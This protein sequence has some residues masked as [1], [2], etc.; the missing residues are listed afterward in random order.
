MF[1]FFLPENAVAERTKKDRVSYDVWAREG[2]IHT[3]PGSSID[4]EFVYKQIAELRK[5]FKFDTI[6]F[7]VWNAQWFSNKLKENGYESSECRMGYKTMSE[8]M[9]EFM[10][11]VLEKKLEHYGDPV[12]AWNAGNVAATTDAMENIKP[13]K[14]KSKEKIDGIVAIIMALALIIENPVLGETWSAYDRRGI[15]FL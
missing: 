6:A 12:L 11:M 4:H 13:D 5:M 3:C 7:D 15:V 9:K 14:S 8:P 2:F 10:G 1:G